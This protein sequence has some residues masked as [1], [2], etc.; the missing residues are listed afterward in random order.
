MDVVWR[1]EARR[2]QLR[3]EVDQG[4]EAAVGVAG[5]VGHA[6]EPDGAGDMHR[7]GV[8]PRPPARI[9]PGGELVGRQQPARGQA[10]AASL[11][12]EAGAARPGVVPGD[13]QQ[14][15]CRPGE[16]QRQAA[17]AEGARQQGRCGSGVKCRQPVVAGIGGAPQRRAQAAF[18]QQPETEEA[19]RGAGRDVDEMVLPGGQHGNSDEQRPTMHQQ[20]PGAGQ[21]QLLELEPDQDEQGD[22]QRRRLV[23]RLVE[24]TQGGEHGARQAVG[25]WAGE[26]EAQREG[27][28]AGDG[29]HL[30]GEQ[31][32]AVPVDGAGVAAAEE[33]QP[34]EEVDR[35]V[36]DDGPGAGR[37]TAFPRRNTGWPPPRGWPPAGSPGRS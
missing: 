1:G 9:E 3:A 14:R 20:A 26:G 8:A 33:G 18:R 13:Q 28:K 11:L 12:L 21:R 15:Q 27:E 24:G 7:R 6:A 29:D 31:A 23:V 22:V 16:E 25:R 10:V 32:L 2:R 37:A 17:E 4:A 30:R 35:P 5:V 36:G 19:E 34:V